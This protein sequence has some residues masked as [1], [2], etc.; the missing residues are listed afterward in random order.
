MSP[1]IAG[2]RLG[3]WTKGDVGGEVD[4]VHATARCAVT[5][6]VVVHIWAYIAVLYGNVRNHIL[7]INLSRNPLSGGYQPPLYIHHF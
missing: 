4:R 2:W 5:L 3:S 1:N 6:V 7:L